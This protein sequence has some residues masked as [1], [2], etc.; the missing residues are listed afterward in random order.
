MS[1]NIRKKGNTSTVITS[2]TTTMIDNL[3]ICY[4][5]D[6]PTTDIE[7][8]FRVKERADVTFTNN[9]PSYLI[10]PL[11]SQLDDLNKT[12]ID[13]VLAGAPAN[14]AQ[15]K[16]AFF[17]LCETRFNHEGTWLYMYAAGNFNGIRPFL[18]NIVDNIVTLTSGNYNTFITDITTDYGGGI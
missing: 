15:Y 8:N 5:F 13:L 11:F 7:A 4:S 9:I 1:F 10:T 2:L 18:N 3:V 14:I 16:T 12:A 17:N 6:I